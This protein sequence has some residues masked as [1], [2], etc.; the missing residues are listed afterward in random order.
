MNEPIYHH[1][2]PQFYLRR[3]TG[4]DGR[5]CR[6]SKPYGDLIVAKRV[7]PKGTG[8]RNLLYTLTSA[9][10]GQAQ[11]IEKG[12]MHPVDTLASDALS[13][14]E[15]GDHRLLRDAKYRSAWSRFIMSLM[16]RMPE[17]ISG[18]QQAIGEEWARR[19]PELSRKYEEL[20]SPSDPPTFQHYLEQRADDM[21]DWALQTNRSLIDHRRIGEI[22]NNMR[23]FIRSIEGGGRKYL[24]S[25]RPVFMID[26]LNSPEAFIMLPIS[27]TSLFVAVNNIETQRRVEAMEPERHIESV[28]QTAAG[29]AMECVYGQDDSLRDFVQEHFGTRRR[30]SVMDRM[31]AY[32]KRLNASVDSELRS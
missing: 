16:L 1:F 24:T 11:Q 21:R 14:L 30:P 8:G 22:L 32:R 15:S 12:F 17:D 2:L 10:D 5:L 6:F 26:E 7:S 20:R 23:W 3:W 28:N 9:P 4:S 19:M 18:L 25:D 13:M 31:I 27:P 29:R